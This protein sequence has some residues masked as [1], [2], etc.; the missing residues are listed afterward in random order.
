MKLTKQLEKEILKVYNTYWEAYLNGDMRAFTSMLD[1]NVRI[2]GSSQNEAFS[3]K[4]AA[5]KFYKATASQIA[6]NAELRNRKISMMPVEDDIMINEQSDFYIL[7]NDQWTFYAHGRISTLFHKTRNKWKIIHQHGSLPDSKAGEGEQ[8]NTEQIKAENLQLRDAVK[9]RTIELENKNRELEIETAL[10]KVRAIAMGMKD[11]V[12]MLQV[13]KNISLQLQSLGVKDIR[14]VQTAIFYKQRGSYM[15]YEYY[16]KHNKTFITETIYTNHK[17]AKAFAAKMLKGKGEIS[18]THIKGKKVREWIAYQKTTNVFIDRFLEKASSLH[19]YWHSLG[20]VALG[21]STYTPLNKDELKLF[22]RF[23]NVFELAYTRYL[24]IEQALVQA[25]EARI[26]L[27]LER[28]RARAMAMQH[29]DE[30]AELVAT[31]FKELTHLDFSLTSCIIWIHDHEHSSNTLW[32]ASAEMNKPAQPFQIK[33]FH[34]NF[35]KSIVPAWKAKDPKWIYALTGSEKKTFEKAFFKEIPNLPDALRKALKVP[36]QVVFSAS[37]NNFGALEIVETEAL[38]DEK[39]NILHRFGKVFDS[40]YTRFNDLKQAEAQAREA[41]IE[42]ALEKIRSRSL[43]MHKSD[44]LWEVIAVVFEKL[45]ELKFS[46]DGAAFIITFSEGPR[47]LNTWLAG[48][49]GQSYPTILR[50]P[51]Y[52]SPSIN[53][54]WLAKESELDFFT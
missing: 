9:R 28:V 11:P 24:D 52:D 48:D 22:N 5:V 6:G 41:K 53:D 20:P 49:Q 12:D 26:E 1:E 14:N 13:C 47:V 54:I 27:A 37:F 32:I 18:I 31:V 19:Y 4:K 44:E 38:T 10:E 7:I 50:L 46:I 2:F 33:P 3:N 30:L 40:S 29:S 51:Y 35:F 43:A 34:N 25:K 42:T 8:V 17:L 21:I 39:F 16:A 23:L 15:N 45:Q 36:K